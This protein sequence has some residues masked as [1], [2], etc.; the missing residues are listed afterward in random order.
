MADSSINLE[1]LASRFGCEISGDPKVIITE[2]A[3]LDK[4]NRNSITFMA[5]DTPFQMVL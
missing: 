4:A 5:A 2:V 1:D 3:G